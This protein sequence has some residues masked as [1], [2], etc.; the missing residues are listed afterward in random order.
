MTR[1]IFTAFMAIAACDLPVTSPNL[2]GW[3]PQ[4]LPLVAGAW[5]PCD[6]GE[7]DPCLGEELACFTPVVD[8]EVGGACT[9]TCQTD[10]DCSDL[11]V[12]EKAYPRCL[13]GTCELR[14]FEFNEECPE[15]M[16]CREARENKICVWPGSEN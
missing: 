14:C 9:W 8:G 11:A 2:P 15:G 4:P 16:T 12:D 6:E 3:P 7:A 1:T 10:E 5:D 13:E